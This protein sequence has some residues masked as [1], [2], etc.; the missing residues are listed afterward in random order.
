MSMNLHLY[1]KKLLLACDII[2]YAPAVNTIDS[3]DVFVYF[4]T[5]KERFI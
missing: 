1:H 2:N 3:R 5:G 4:I